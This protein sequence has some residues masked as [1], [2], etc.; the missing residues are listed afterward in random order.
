MVDAH[1]QGVLLLL[2]ATLAWSTSGLFARAIPLD[3]PTVILWRGLAGAAGLIFLLWW[4]RG[5]SGFGDFAR[6]GRA[7]WGYAFASGMGMLFFV[8]SLKATSI[9][10][11]AIIYATL[12]FVAAFLG[13]LILKEAPG[14]AGIAAAALALAGA[15]VMVGLGGDG[16]WTGDLMALG[17]VFA[18]SGMILIA[19]GNPAMPALAAGVVSALWAPLAMAPFSTL[20]GLDGPNLLLL[21]AF[22]LVNSSAGLALFIYGSR[23]TTPVETALIGALETAL[24]PLWVWMIF[25]ET[26]TTPTLIG[27]G[28]VLAASVGHIL[29]TARR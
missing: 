20:Q 6:L 22:G 21:L 15:V 9:A 17:M 27:G 29:W 5:R 8:G 3:T 24:T 16:T 4:L 2:G 18:M 25:T 12:P 13:W 11:V 19:R 14:R 7:G 28:M 10:H 1:R 26:P 23:N